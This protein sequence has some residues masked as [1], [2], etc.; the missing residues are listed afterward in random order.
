M[1]GGLECGKTC[2]RFHV[3]KQFQSTT[4]HVC[5]C[6][7][8]TCSIHLY[9][10]LP[11]MSVM[12]PLS[13]SSLLCFLYLPG[14]S[15]F[16]ILCLSRF[17]FFVCH[18]LYFLFVTFCIFCLS[19]FVLFV[20]FCFVCHVLFCLSRFVLFVTFFFV[21]HV[22]FC[23]LQ[24]FFVIMTVASCHCFWKLRGLA[25]AGKR[26]STQLASKLYWLMLL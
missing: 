22:L 21:C 8:S 7:N 16:F 26:G 24:M 14:F 4:T 5:Y 11:T 19:R 17:V 12:L 13:C 1:Q 6:L 18:V 23:L 10:I 20:T 9:E 3:D 15:L 25:H 2:H